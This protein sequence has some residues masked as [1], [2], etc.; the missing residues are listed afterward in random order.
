MSR[1]RFYLKTI[2]KGQKRWTPRN[3]RDGKQQFLGGNEGKFHGTF[4]FMVQKHE[5]VDNFC[6]FQ[7]LIAATIFTMCELSSKISQKKG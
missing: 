7:L 5:N 6:E 3:V 4:T 2:I 1:S